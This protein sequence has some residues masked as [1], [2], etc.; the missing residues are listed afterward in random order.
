MTRRRETAFVF[1]LILASWAVL[2]PLEARTGHPGEKASVARGEVCLLQSGGDAVQLGGVPEYVRASGDQ[3]YP[4][5]AFGDGVALVVWEDGRWGPSEIYAA[6][7]SGGEVL[8]PSGI[9]VGAGEDFKRFPACAF[10][11]GKF[12]VVW[13]EGFDRIMGRFISSAGELID[14]QPFEIC[15]NTG[16]WSPAVASS[17]SLFLVVWHDTRSFET[18]VYGARVTFSGD[19]LD[20]NGFAI[21][22]ERFEQTEAAVASDGT[23]FLV[24]WQDRR[25]GNWSTYGARV[26]SSGGVLDGSGI[27]ICDLLDGFR[28]T[29]PDV[30]FCNSSYVVFWQ[31]DRSGQRKIFG[32]RVSVSGAV[33]DGTGVQTCSSQGEQF[34]P[35]LSFNG[36]SVLVTWRNVSLAENVMFCLADTLLTGTAAGA[37]CQRAA[38]QQAPSVCLAD[39]EW[40]VAWMDFRSNMDDDVYACRVS[41]GGASQDSCGFLVSE[42]ANSQRKPRVAYDGTRHLVVWEDDRNGDT[43]IYGTRVSSSGEVM[44]TLGIAI[45]RLSAE[46]YLPDVASNGSNFLVVWTDDRLTTDIYGH[47]INSSGE[48]VGDIAVPVSTSAGMQTAPSVATD[49]TTYFCVWEDYRNG[50]DGDIYGARVSSSGLVLDNSGLLVSIQ[51]SEHSQRNPSVDFL[52]TCYVVAWEDDRGGDFDAYAARVTP[53]G[54]VLDSSGIRVSS[55]PL[56][57]LA[58]DICCTEHQCLVLWEE[59]STG[60]SDSD[61]RGAR[62]SNSGELLDTSSVLVSGA[63]GLQIEPCVAPATEGFL[64]VWT[65]SRPGN[66]DIY[67][68]PVTLAGVVLDEG[69][70]GVSKEDRTENS[71]AVSYQGGGVSLTAWSGLSGPPYESYRIWGKAGAWSE[72]TPAFPLVWELR[73]E[74]DEEGVS[75]SWKAF[76]GFFDAF[77]VERRCDANLPWE[78][79]A[80]VRAWQSEDY[81]YKDTLVPA[82]FCRYR[83]FCERLEGRAL[84]FEFEL[85]ATG[86]EARALHLGLPAPNP[87]V[88]PGEIAFEIEASAAVAVEILDVSGVLVRRIFSGPAGSTVRLLRW[89]GKDWEGRRVAPGVYFLRLSAGART[90]SRKIVVLE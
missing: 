55:S 54:E 12:L 77:T 39:S 30:A 2:T 86:R 76:P 42:R 87:A 71:P 64:G 33:L 75:L 10:G 22:D 80:S 9:S 23:Q 61:V 28:R 78:M 4:K 38:P 51:G 70:A 82:A 44:D 11:D 57:D 56:S 85:E 37:F 6:R 18:D 45:M 68:T 72:L 67:G 32:S 15:S 36:A 53:L 7:I 47:R 27:P 5:S 19:V 65:D 60:P 25:V 79:V 58:P 31:D 90:A 48:V 29:V 62:I 40:L 88:F 1:T 84:V 8:D 49:G 89:D 46:Q 43:D 13:Q 63:S 41:F 73:A 35:A 26:D 20:P 69:G 24:V 34:D 66:K 52:D 74:R 17:D 14:E 16:P 50:N 83:L 81:F 59:R 21:S 3:W